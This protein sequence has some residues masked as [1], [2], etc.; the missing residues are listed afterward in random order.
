MTGPAVERFYVSENSQNVQVLIFQ[1]FDKLSCGG[2]KSVAS[3]R[4]WRVSAQ[5]R[6][7]ETIPY[8]QKSL[9]S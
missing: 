1:W 6:K 7:R 5:L 9:L 8:P 4:K 3:G 2:P